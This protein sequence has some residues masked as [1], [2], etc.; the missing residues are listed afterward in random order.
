MNGILLNASKHWQCPSCD[1]EH[2][3]QSW[4]H[5]Y[6]PMHNCPKLGITAPYIEAGTDAIHVTVERDDYIGT[7]IVRLAH[8]RPVMSVITKRADGSNDS[9]V[10]APAATATVNVN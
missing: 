2:V 9:H 6:P 10:Y 7:D 1:G 3:T 5:P 4:P 8:G